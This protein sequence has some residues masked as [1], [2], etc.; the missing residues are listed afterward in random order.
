MGSY[1]NGG[2]TDHAAPRAHA[3]ITK[4]AELAV[5]NTDEMEQALISAAVV[6]YP[7]NYDS[8][9]RRS[10]DE[11]FAAKMADVYARFPDNA[12]VATVYAVA[13]FMLEERRGYRDLND[14]DLIRLHGVLSGVLDVDIRHPGACHLYI[15]ATESSEQPELGLPCAEYLGETVRVASHIQHMPSHTWNEVGMWGRSVRANTAAYQSDLKSRENEG[16]SYAPT[17]NLHM[18][19]FAASFDG[20]GAVATQA[21]T[22]YRKESGNSM[23]EVLTLIRFG[24]FDEVLENTRRPD[25]D[26]AAALWDFARG[27]ASLKQ[28]DME[29]AK[30]M[31]DEILQFAATTELKFRFHPAGRVIGTAAHIL[32]GEILWTEGDL[33]G[34]ITA[35][36]KSVEVEDSMDYDEP[37]PLPFAARHWL[38]AALLE[39]GRYADA[40]K[41]YRDELID[42]PHNGWSLFGVQAALAGQGRHDPAVD[43]DFTESWARSDV[44][45]TSSKF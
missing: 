12:D 36:E 32:E 4:A 28:G 10:V 29:T 26:V 27:Y 39:A 31:R 5:G 43:I 17:H 38:G 16:F 34:A 24:R 2:M 8:Q 35:F 30:V 6:R 9:N 22:D 15:H 7:E 44:W 1:L 45:I 18:L 42:H 21:G 23:Y 14:P 11:A 19:L 33:D 13:L 20:Q 41:A 40:E 3:A 37:E 25:N